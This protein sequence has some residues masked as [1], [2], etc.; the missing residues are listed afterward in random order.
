MDLQGVVVLHLML[1]GV[2]VAGVFNAAVTF[3]VT[4]AN[5]R[6]LRCGT[7]HVGS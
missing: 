6:P 1:N 3:R 2:L 5:R 4:V 7:A